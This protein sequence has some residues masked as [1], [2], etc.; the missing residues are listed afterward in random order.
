MAL[1]LLIKYAEILWKVFSIHLK[2][3][4]VCLEILIDLLVGTLV[5]RTIRS[6][7]NL[8]NAEQL[9]RQVIRFFLLI[10]TKDC[11]VPLRPSSCILVKWP[12]GSYIEYLIL[13]AH[14]DILVRS[15][16]VPCVSYSMDVTIYA[17]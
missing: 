14:G 1:N 16:L 15:V 8:N 13:C 12:R 9:L 11:N 17:E 10:V 7:L 4:L 2:Q 6:Y 5:E 3:L